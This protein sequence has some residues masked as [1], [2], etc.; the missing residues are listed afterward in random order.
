MSARSDQTHGLKVRFILL[1]VTI[2]GMVILASLS[3][4]SWVSGATS[5]AVPRVT[6]IAQ[7]TNDGYRKAS[8]LADDSQLF[9]TEL[10]ASNRMIAKVMLPGSNRTVLPSPFSSLQALDLSADHSKLLISAQQT[11]GEDEFWSLPVSNGKPQRIGNLSGR[12]ASWSAD[13]KDLAFAKGHVLYLADSEGKQQRTL[14]KANGPIFALRF[15]PNGRRIRFTVSDPEKNT[16]ALWEVGRDGKNPHELLSGW[17]A[18]STACCGSWTPDG[19]YY[20]FQASQTI[21]YTSTVMTSLWALPEATVD[22][23][24]VGPVQLTNGPMSF[25]NASLGQGGKSLWAIGVQPSV[26]VVKYEPKKQKYFPVIAGLSATDLEYSHD[27]KWVAYVSVPEGTLWKA[28]ANGKDRVQLTLG[29]DRT[30]LPRW[31]PD[32][33]QIAFASMK[34]GESWKLYV[35]PSEGGE[36]APLIRGA[37]S[38][39]DANWSADGSKL[40]FGDMRLAAKGMMIRI[41]DFKNNKIE[42]VPGSENLFSPRWSPN[43][44]YIAAISTDNTTLMLFDSLTGKWS[45]WLKESAGTVSYPTWSSDSQ[46]LYFDDVVNGAEAIRRVGVT[47]H[48]PEQVLEVGS[49]DRYPGPLGVWSGRTADGSW[50]FVR[51]RSTQEV[52]QLSLELP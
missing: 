36:S 42:N 31:S 25:G 17:E 21:P 47:S 19:R 28:R 45:I 16:T 43:E 3:P 37:G 11:S 50:M 35:I 44:R 51:D 2:V 27:G 49:L 14:F 30:A 24:G 38:Q 22:D 26:E 5:A 48:E 39:I 41:Y 10:P 13:G 20:I 33:T 8:L 1:I 40:L 23:A 4:R 12:D 18:K 9:V 32:G 46:F 15:S 7:V 52:Y 6:S 29:P 34:P